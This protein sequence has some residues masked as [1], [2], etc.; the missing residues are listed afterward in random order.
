MSCGTI[1][2]L[3]GWQPFQV[4]GTVPVA[5]GIAPCPPWIGII[6]AVVLYCVGI[7][8]GLPEHSDR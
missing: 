5:T 6:L 3:Y 4:W 2:C 7:C 8:V 1:A